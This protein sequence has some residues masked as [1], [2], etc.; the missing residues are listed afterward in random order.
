MGL[1]LI[2][3][4]ECRICKEEKQL[5][6][7]N[8]RW[9][10]DTSKFRN[11][12]IDCEEKQKKE[13]REKNK[14]KVRAQARDRW[15]S[16]EETRIKGRSYKL[17]R[18]FGIDIVEYNR[19]FEEQNGCCKICNIHQSE[20]KRSLAVDHCH[21]HEEETGEILIRGLL[22]DNCNLGLGNFQDNYEAILL[23]AEYI[24]TNGGL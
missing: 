19:I 4:K 1:E 20:V 5:N 21:K 22:C 11:A 23:A 10:K 7:S 2:E 6:T 16:C 24:K 15:A 8:F 3:F 14:D 9:R 12:C 13:Y 17:K 18:E